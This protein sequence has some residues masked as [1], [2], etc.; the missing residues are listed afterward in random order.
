M[1]NLFYLLLAVIFFSSCEK[2]NDD[3]PVVTLT[4]S[5]SMGAGYAS[6]V[7]YSLKDGVVKTSPRANWDIA[8]STD[9]MSS[10]VLINEGYGLKVYT[11][12]NGDIEAWDNVDITDVESWTA[13][14]NSDT[15][16]LN[17]AFDRNATGHPDYGWGV[18]NTQSHDVI[19]DSI[20][21]VKL[22]DGSYKK[23][24]IEK[25]AAMTNS[26]SVK[27]G[28]IDAAGETKEIA[29]APYISKNFIYFSLTSGEV[30]D[31]EPESS[32]WDIVFTKYYDESIPYIVTGVL[33]NEN[34]EIAE[35]RGVE[36]ELAEPENGVYSSYIDII[37][38]DWKSFDMGTFTYVIE[39]NLSYFVK[40]STE[41]VYKVVF[42]GTDGST[43]GKMV[44][45]VEK[46]E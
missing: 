33:A 12:P 38:S 16:W 42:T 22:S 1:K 7:Y 26:F 23:L 35:V 14:Y 39:E 34:T 6:D 41:E 18:Y 15:T 29:C 5:I 4:D 9:P 13:M 30:V 44:F 8:F 20:F 40:T 28:N 3:N 27:Y 37:G 31:N 11:Y 17:G 45:T 10:T 25:R 24:F 2:G 21:I 36:T 46:A 32:A 19:G 43:S